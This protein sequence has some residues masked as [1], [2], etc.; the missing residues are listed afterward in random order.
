[1]SNERV[2]FERW[3]TVFLG[4]AMFVVALVGLYFQKVQVDGASGKI[5]T[6]MNEKIEKMQTAV[7]E[8]LEKVEKAQN[9]VVLEKQLADMKASLVALEGKYP[10]Q[11]KMLTDYSSQVTQK[12][13]KLSDVWKGATASMVL[14]KLNPQP[15]DKADLT[16]K[17][18]FLKD[19]DKKSL[20]SQFD[21]LRRTQD[22][23]KSQTPITLS[24]LQMPEKKP[25]YEQ[26]WETLKANPIL[27]V[28]LIL[29]GV[30]ASR[31]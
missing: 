21:S 16:K 30:A 27:L 19:D 25:W 17:F 22:L 13:E 28:I 15:E 29:L 23:I 5:I 2:P 18:G 14:S 12:Q 9:V 8:R 6:D 31:K 4:L 11:K 24:P 26:L 7:N 1:M 3:L 10:E 20:T